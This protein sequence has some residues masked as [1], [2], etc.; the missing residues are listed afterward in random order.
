MSTDAHYTVVLSQAFVAGENELKKLSDLLS[1]RIGPLEIRADC[2]DEVTRTF[3]SVK[4]L[5]AY[6]NSRPKAIRCLRMVAHS[7]DFKKRA[8]ITLSGSQ[9]RGISLD[10]DA[11]DDVVSR[12]RADVLES[13]DGMRPWY[14]K[15]HRVDFVSMMLLAYFM[16]WIGL[17]IY[18]ASHPSSGGTPKETSPSSS[19][20]G[21]LV[22]VGLVVLI[23]GTGITLNRFRDAIF[24]RAIFRIGQGEARFQHLE[25]C[26]WGIVIS[27]VVSFV[28]GA[29]I[30]VWQMLAA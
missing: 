22:I 9:W 1:D 11:R 8:S 27:F 18:F 15:L 24:P 30:A 10:F 21:N 12:L 14:S 5:V 13:L 28:G 4:E 19:A 25:R 7:E 17:S 20:L 29:I 2:A 3:K 16:L 23:F 26:Q 6:E